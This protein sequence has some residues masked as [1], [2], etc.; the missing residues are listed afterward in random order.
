MTGTCFFFSDDAYIEHNIDT[1]RCFV[2]WNIHHIYYRGTKFYYFETRLEIHAFFTM[3]HFVFQDKQFLG[4]VNVTFLLFYS[5][6]C[7]YTVVNSGQQLYNE[8]L[9]LKGGL[10]KLSSSLSTCKYLCFHLL[11]LVYK[12]YFEFL[13]ALS[14]LSKCTYIVFL[15]GGATKGVLKTKLTL[16]KLLQNVL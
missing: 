12:M 15:C 11:M 13:Y 5:L 7:L 10:S 8:Y 16:N 2:Q 6:L 4:L 14:I 3:E 1:E 9:K